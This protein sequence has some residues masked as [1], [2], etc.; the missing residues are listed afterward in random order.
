V[1]VTG[2]D[3]ELLAQ[4]NDRTVQMFFASVSS[5]LSF[6]I[7]IFLHNSVCNRKMRPSSSRHEIQPTNCV[8]FI[9][10]VYLYV[11]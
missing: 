3:V 5:M 8:I 6:S 11:F 7:S 2:H 9:Y 4:V 1:N 10:I